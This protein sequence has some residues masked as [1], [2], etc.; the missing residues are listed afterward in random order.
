MGA[1]AAEV[2]APLGTAGLIGTPKPDASVCRYCGYDF[3]AWLPVA[4]RPN[5]ATLLHHLS[6]MHPKTPASAR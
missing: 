4:K 3:P 5:G 1:L 2:L 6:A